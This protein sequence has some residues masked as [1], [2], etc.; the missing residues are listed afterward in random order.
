MDLPRRLQKPQ[1][2]VTSAPDVPGI[3]QRA[4]SHHEPAVRAEEG[5]RP[6]QR[7]MRRGMKARTSPVGDVIA[8]LPSSR[9]QLEPAA[10]SASMDSL[11][12]V[13]KHQVREFGEDQWSGA[14]GA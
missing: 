7:D 14:A 13:C 5:S 8:S 1:A 2:V 9:S 10:A 12:G 11:V 6:K 4:H 3:R